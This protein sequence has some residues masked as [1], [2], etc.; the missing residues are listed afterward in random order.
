MGVLDLYKELDKNKTSDIKI[1]VSGEVQELFP[2]YQKPKP[3]PQPE[4]IPQ[5]IPEP[6]DKPAHI[7]LL[8][9]VMQEEDRGRA[10]RESVRVKYYTLEDQNAP[11]IEFQKNHA[12]ITELTKKLQELYIRRRHIEIHGKAPEKRAI[13]TEE[14]N[15]ALRRLKYD[16]KCLVDKLGKLKRKANNYL[17]QSNGPANLPRWENE[18]D[19]VEL[20]I[21]ELD[22]EIDK[23]N[24]V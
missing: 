14:E 2:E 21:Y 23:I 5:S 3:A 7:T 22:Q 9:Q 12:A 8:Q 11:R 4:P 24:G 19:E 15:N 1:R 17:A 13:I 6:D 10:H 20:K 16:R 18:I